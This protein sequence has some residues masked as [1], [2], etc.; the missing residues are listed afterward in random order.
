MTFVTRPSTSSS[1]GWTLRH[2]VVGC[3][4]EPIGRVPYLT[5]TPAAAAE[6][7]LRS[8]DITLGACADLQTIEVLYSNEEI[9]QEGLAAA[10]DAIRKWMPKL[11]DRVRL[12]SYSPTEESSAPVEVGDGDF[13]IRPFGELLKSDWA[14]EL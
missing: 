13:V 6:Q 3:A 7:L 11:K 14:Y 4:H 10:K 1:T 9:E 2:L 12:T 5:Y 8:V